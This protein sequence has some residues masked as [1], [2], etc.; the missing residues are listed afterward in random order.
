[1][2][3]HV[4]VCRCGDPR[5]RGI[6]A[7]NNTAPSEKCSPHGGYC[8]V[9]DDVD[10]CSFIWRFSDGSNASGIIMSSEVE[11]GGLNASVQFGG[12]MN[13]TVSFFE[14][15]SGGG[16]MGLSFGNYSLC[17]TQ[18]SCFPPIIDQLV[19]QHPHLEN[20]FAL[21]A[22]GPSASLIVGRGD[23]KLTSS[24]IQYVEL[25]EPH[26][27]YYIHVV[28]VRVGDV[29]IMDGVIAASSPS[30]KLLRGI[31]PAALSVAR[32]RRAG[33][34]GLNSGDGTELRAMVDSGNSASVMPIKLYNNL[35][36]HLGRFFVG[37]ESKLFESRAVY[38]PS[39]RL[40]TLPPISIIL[41]NDVTLTL[42]PKQYLLE[43]PATMVTPGA[44]APLYALMF[45]TMPH[46]DFM[47]LGQTLLSHM[48]I[49]VDRAAKKIG[50][51]MPAPGCSLKEEGMARR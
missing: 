22:D 16:I 18:A 46:L 25:E 8:S 36:T 6:C 35:Q 49:E 24:P 20:K 12:I 1:M 14:M 9:Y 21:C 10:Y 23:S 38:L 2:L 4:C 41:E 40:S 45:Y 15:P 13:A 39:E 29:S 33:G 7:A 43:I 34:H 3:V 50:F 30:P 47:V 42:S 32:E 37:N 48:Y 31:S 11:L 28:D 44:P 26:S 5:C 51:A 19:D 17:E 27:F